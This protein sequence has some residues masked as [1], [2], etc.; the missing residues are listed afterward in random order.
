MPAPERTDDGRWIVVG[1]RRW[2]AQDPTL[3]PEIAARLRSHLGRAR[4]AVRGASEP[5]AERRARDRVQLAKEGLGE[6]GTAW[7][8]LPEAERASRALDRLESLDETAPPD[9]RR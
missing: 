8:E 4:A 1:G 3:E 5:G 2:R 9:D 6:R 7:W